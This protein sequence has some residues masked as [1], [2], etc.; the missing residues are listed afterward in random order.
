MP[1][2]TNPAS[3]LRTALTHEADPAAPLLE[4]IWLLT[5]FAALLATAFPWFVSGFNIDF[6]AASLALLAL[7]AIYVGM[8][9]AATYRHEGRT[10]RWLSALLNAAG[11]I[12]LG[13]LWRHAGGLQ[14]PAF[15]IAFLLPV[16]AS[17][18]L[19]R[20]QPYLTAGVAVLTVA[21]VAA[22]QDPEL[23]WYAAAR[24]VVRWIG[25][26]SGAHDALLGF[27]APVAYD[28]VLLEVFAILIFACAVAT[29]S[30]NN[31][32]GKLL[33]HLTGAQA[34]AASGQEM[35][36]GILK[37]LPVPAL[38][39]DAES[40]E[41]IEASDP[42][43][44][45]CQ[46][47]TSGRKLFDVLRFSQPEPIQ[48]LVERSGGTAPFMGLRLT[49][50]LRIVDVKVSHVLHEN[51]R[52]ALVVLFDVTSS[53]CVS[54]AADVSEQAV[55][56]MDPR[57]KP[58]WANRPARSLFPDGLPP[59]TTATT[60]N[61]PALWWQPGFSGRRRLRMTLGG[62]SYQALCTAVALSGER[63]DCYV[64]AM[65]PASAANQAPAAETS[66]THLS[67]TR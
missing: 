23:S 48:T 59:A 27:Y 13:V 25:A 3:A 28:V 14:N 45:F 10:N 33:T 38:L 29:E 5:I 22:L 65:T 18:A 17:G 26:P 60:P 11:V 37:G 9:L 1:A 50:D 66:I 20:W 56:V 62:R 61:G 63:E 16:F 46:A 8:N 19:S 15:L 32:F 44:A 54:S 47:Q 40:L 30:I 49:D 12:T 24:W 36:L 53:F 21:S 6:A 58:L 64:V 43:T 34:E 52:L 39:L 67:R 41:I 42:T 31:A 2:M 55:F 57:G 51:R 4:D 7:G 35:W